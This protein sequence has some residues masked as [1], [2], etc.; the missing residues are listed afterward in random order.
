MKK[1]IY[2][3]K[4]FWSGVSFIL[5]AVG[6]IIILINNWDNMNS[7]RN[8]KSILFTII[9]ALIGIVQIYRGI[10]SKCAKDDHQDDD[11]RKKLVILK[12][13]S[14]T[15]KITFNISIVLTLLL[16]VAIGVT[17]NNDLSGVFVGVAIMPTIMIIS[18]MFANY[19]HN[20]RN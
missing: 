11:E 1:K 14:S 2:N 19:Y 15:Y 10:D 8:G 3:K 6:Y 12:T 20:K 16:A 4:G 5:L 9:C 7:I 18:Y 13:E 17:K